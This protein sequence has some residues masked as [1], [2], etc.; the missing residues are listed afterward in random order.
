MDIAWWRAA[1]DD[2][3]QYVA[4]LQILGKSLAAKMPDKVKA[5]LATVVTLDDGQRLVQPATR[6]LLVGK[7]SKAMLHEDTLNPAR[8]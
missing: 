5:G 2:E 1:P 4:S 6:P 3:V 8:I 7:F